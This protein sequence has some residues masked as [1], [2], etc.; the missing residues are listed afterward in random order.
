MDWLTIFVAATSTTPKPLP[1]HPS[2]L[3]SFLRS[4]T[5]RTHPFWSLWLSK[6]MWNVKAQHASAPRRC[7]HFAVIFCKEA[8]HFARISWSSRGDGYTRRRALK[9][10]WNWCAVHTRYFVCLLVDFS[11]HSS[12]IY[13]Y[14]FYVSTFSCDYR[15]A[16]MPKSPR[17]P[18]PHQPTAS[19]C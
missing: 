13:S 18:P 1:R 17:T 14:N 7:L 15:G 9:V 12:R 11:F 16:A 5:S 4:K 10:C 6:T 19:T 8:L 3:S 2:P